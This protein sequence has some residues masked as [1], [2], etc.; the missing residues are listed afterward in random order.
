D[1]SIT[2]GQGGGSAVQGNLNIQNAT[3]VTLLDLPIAGLATITSTTQ[4]ISDN[5]NLSGVTSVG[6]NLTIQTG[7]AADNVT[8][9]ATTIMNGGAFINLGN[10]NGGP[11]TLNAIGTVLGTLTAIGGTG[12]DNMT[13]SG[14]VGSN[15]TLMAGSGANNLSLSSLTV[16]GTS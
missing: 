15:V 6:R 3:T 7:N 11:D 14:T 8:L 1:D 9:A 16:L 10:S 5:I 12:G 4:A 13:V 2:M